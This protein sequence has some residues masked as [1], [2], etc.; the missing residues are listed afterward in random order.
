[1]QHAA[2]FLFTR[3]ITY[4]AKYY[5]S[6][7]AHAYYEAYGDI[8]GGIGSYPILGNPHYHQSH[9][10]LETINQELVAEVSRATVASVMALASSPA[11]LS[12]LAAERQSGAVA[13]RWTPAPERGV[14]SYVVRFRRSGEAGFERVTVR[15]PL[16][17]LPD[18]P[19]GST[20][21]VKAV[22]GS[23]MEGWDWARLIFDP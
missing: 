15:Q 11:R 14:E 20:I 13:V 1:L 16:A 12:G 7:D 4:D 23:G 8:V 6:T 9:D 10:V 17:T 2:A 5:K 21:E 19:A 18:L 22:S 3:L